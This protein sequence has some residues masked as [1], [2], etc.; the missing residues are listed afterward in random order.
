MDYWD[1]VMQ[2][3]VH[4]VISDGWLDAAKPRA[5]IEDK[6]RQIKETPDLTVQRRRYKM[7]LVPPRLIVARWFA[8]EQAELDALRATHDAA[9][10]ALDAFVEDQ[11]STADGEDGPLAAA[12]NDKGRVTKAGVTARLLEV[13]ADPDSH[14]EMEPLQRCLA[15]MT[16]E[17]AAARAVKTAQATLDARALARYETLTEDEI[18]TVAVDDKWF[19]NIRRAVDGDGQEV[20]RRF[21]D[22][23]KDLDRRYA[24]PLP[25]LE[26]KVD[27][28]S[29]ELRRRLHQMGYARE[30]DVDIDSQ[31]STQ[32]RSMD[33]N[34]QDDA[35]LITALV[36]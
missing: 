16:A 31:L 18:R 19:G 33:P 21:A 17:T 30:S 28:L 36:W 1:D 29:V 9:A 24:R 13:E 34:T 27:A 15:L 10:Q 20:M 32:S 11:A 25:Q 7:D 4:L 22:R 12:V 6:H 2:D 8:A 3:D 5:T 26:R 14:E 35:V 23:V